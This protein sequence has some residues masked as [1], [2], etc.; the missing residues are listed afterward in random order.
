VKCSGIG[1]E[2]GEEGLAEY[3]TIQIVNVNKSA[4]A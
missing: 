3:T 2:F 1:V 4:A